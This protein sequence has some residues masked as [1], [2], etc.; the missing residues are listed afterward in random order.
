MAS[1]LFGVVCLTL[2]LVVLVGVTGHILF[3][4]GAD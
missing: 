3:G 2:M 1:S 4:S